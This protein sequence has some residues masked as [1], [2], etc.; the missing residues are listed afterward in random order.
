VTGAALPA[1]NPASIAARATAYW[2]SKAL[3]TAVEVGLFDA[4][5]AGANRESLPATLGLA[6]RGASTLLDAMLTAGLITETAG[7]L[8]LAPGADGLLTR[9][10]EDSMAAALAYNG[11]LY[12][13]WDNLGAAVKSGHPVVP[14]QAHLG[15]DPAQTRAFVMGMHARAGLTVAALAR[16]DLSASR[17]LLD[18]A[19]GPGTVGR[20]LATK[21]PQL[22]VTLADLPGVTTVAR[23]LSANHPARSRVNHVD[24][25][26]RTDSLP[27]ADCAIDTVLWCGA[28]HQHNPDEVRSLLGRL[29]TLSSPPLRLI[30]VD[31]L[32]DENIPTHPSSEFAALFGLNM[33]LFSSTSHMYRLGEYAELLSQTGWRPLAPVTAAGHYRIIE[34][35]S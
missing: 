15:Q 6:P 7:R 9:T 1:V 4:V 26:Y 17:H 22:S 14:P 29:H 23:E 33:S 31:Y 8:T 10:G 5:S 35:T 2:Q 3:V 20:H 18:L 30:T 24:L 13:L 32:I 27:V 11:R 21:F 16:L 12:S 25:D 19:S 28:L 34:A